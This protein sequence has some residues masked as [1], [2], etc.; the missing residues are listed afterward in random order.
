MSS[1]PRIVVLHM[2]EIIYTLIFASFILLLVF[3]L[4]FMFNDKNK[5]NKDA[6]A[7]TYI[8][9]IYTS[10]ITVNGTPMNLQ[11]TVDKTNITSIELIHTDD[12]IS[13]MYPLLQTSIDDISNQ[14][15]VSQSLDN[16]S[17]PDGCKYTYNA[18]LSKIEGVLNTAK[19]TN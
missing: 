4:I 1:K 13:T 3:L 11:V 15:V 16:I 12:S 18:L 2:K 14:V 10:S 9:G 17:C 5:N 8:P 6:S 7:G 19:A